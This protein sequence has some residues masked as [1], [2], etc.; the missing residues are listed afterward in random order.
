MMLQ[1][2]NKEIT[3]KEYELFRD[4]V[5][6]KCGINLGSQKK[7]LVQSRVG[8]LVRQN[9]LDSFRDYYELVKNDATGKALSDLMDVISTNTTHLFREIRHFEFL[10]EQLDVWLQDADWR[11]NRDA[12]RIWSSACSSGDEPHSM[13]MVIDDAVQKHTNFDYKILATDI[14]TDVLE[15]A[16]QGIY[17][18][19][20]CETV[21]SR[22]K[23]KYLKQARTSDQRQLDPRLLQKISFL[24]FNLMTPK[25]P[26]KNAFDVIF[27]RN[28]MIYFDKA[29]QGTLINKM[30]DHLNPG[31]Y[32]M[33]G[34]SESLNGVNHPLKYV[35]PTVFQK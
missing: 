10:R 1:T 5:Y 26:F 22:L 18:E 21:P 16:K 12:F 14:C 11:K 8:K 33:I 6:R 32:L 24:R 15:T 27:C 4:L 30:V 9:G 28:V 23:T 17:S 2:Q 3:A 19:D 34:H 31:G 25:F 29:T 20:K 13:A 7:N 35:E